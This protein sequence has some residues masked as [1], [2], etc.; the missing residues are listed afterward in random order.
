[1]IIT[2]SAQGIE[3][4]Q[5][6]TQLITDSRSLVEPDST[7]FCAVRTATGDGHRYLV[8]MYRRGVRA[9]IVE[10]VPAELTDAAQAN[11]STF[12]VTDDVRRE[13]SLLAGSRRKLADCRMV[14]ITGSRGK[15]QLKELL[16]QALQQVENPVRSPRSWNSRIGTAMSVFEVQPEHTTALIEVG[17]DGPDQIDGLTLIATMPGICVLD[18]VTDTHDAGFAAAAAE[19]YEQPTEADI[20]RLKIREKLRLGAGA[21]TIIYDT[22][23]LNHA[24]DMDALVAEC[25]PTA[26]L[27]PVHP[28]DRSPE[29][30]NRALAAETLACLG[31]ADRAA[32]LLDGVQNVRSRIDVHEGV[33]DCVMLYDPFTA[34]LRS[35][36]DALDFMRRRATAG[37]EL[38]VILGDLRHWYG[39]DREAVYREADRLLHLYGISRLIGVGREISEY[40][41]CFDPLLVQGFCDT[42][43]DFGVRFGIDR[44]QS[45]LILIKGGPGREFA[46]LKDMLESPRH[47]T[48]MEINLDAMAANFNH[49]RSR[50]RPTTGLIAMV[51]ASGYGVG[52]LETAKT[53]QACR[54]AYL[55]VAVVDEAVALR[56][57]GITMPIL[58]LNPITNNYSALFDRRIEPTVFS[59]HELLTLRAEAEARGLNN[60][61]VHIKLDTGMHRVGFIADELDTLCRHLCDSQVLRVASVFSHLATADEPTMDDYTQL[62]LDTFESMTQ[63]MGRLLPYPFKRHILNTAGMTRYPQYQYDM[64]RLGIGLYGVDPCAGTPYALQPGL[65][66]VARLTTTVIAVRRWPAGTTIGYGRRGRLERESVV[67]TLPIGYADGIDRHFGCG[68][69]SFMVN[70][71]MCPTVGNICMDL[72]MIDVTDAPDVKP[73]DIVEIFGPAAPIDRLSQIRRTI[74]YEIL[75]SVSPRVRRIYFRE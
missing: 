18:S 29:T 8:D 70:G 11:D 33:N 2:D 68:A 72:C 58:V 51:K 36:R 44:F 64:V 69:A 9:F 54:A 38:C 26:Q 65:D 6:Y 50:L 15:T 4:L 71:T 35:L 3:A 25:C 27:H 60:Y 7:I 43:A 23:C 47:D 20:R 10:E 40:A 13:M 48:V 42:A 30:V 73:G 37:R 52:A 61:P 31:Y 17:I 53:L 56:Q 12:V 75:T 14:G 24:E 46:A 32:Q 74:P 5:S 57:A 34:D 41:R 19:M 39:A 45:A 22:D 62:Q 63:Q 67:A 28:A 1:M 21:H 49:Y 16:F 55:A 59:L 66:C